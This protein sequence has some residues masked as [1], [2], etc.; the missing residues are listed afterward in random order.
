MI[1]PPR[2][3]GDRWRVLR[4]AARDLSRLRRMT[5]LI[6]KYGYDGWLRRSPDLPPELGEDAF[7]PTQ[8]VSAEVAQATGARRFR[9]MLE[10]LGPTFIKFG[11]VLSARP[12]LVA[13]SYI[14]E[15][16]H[17][18]D[19][20]EP[21]DS[22]SIRAAIEEELERTPDELF[23]WFDPAPLATA[24]IAQVH[25][26]RTRDGADVV[27]K[28]RRPGIRDAIRGDLDILYRVAQLLEAVVEESQL[29]DPVA[30][31]REFER[32]VTAELDF[33]NEADNLREFGRLHEHRAHVV[34]PRPHESL[35]AAGILVMDYLDGVPFNRLPA[36]CD[37][38]AIARRLA[39]AGATTNEIA[40]VTG[41]RTLAEV[42][43]YTDTAN[44]SNL[45]KSAMGKLSVPD[46]E[47]SVKP[48]MKI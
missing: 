20:C 12:D 35:C 45:G 36:D 21:L 22:A 48:T 4:D 16:K 44:R 9:L 43:R 41:L 29:A 38:K 3:I 40:A 31:V 26:A 24:S 32:A 11:Q 33:R 27:V 46:G 34:I 17:L 13:P 19:H 30:L 39:D 18:Q 28:V 5:R 7:S 37:R 2:R 47:Q 23:A 1:A 8:D 25:R 6:G 14:E 42:Q 15:L 10:E